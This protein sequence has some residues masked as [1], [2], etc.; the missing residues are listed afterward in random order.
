MLVASTP[1]SRRP[2]GSRPRTSRC[3]SVAHGERR[4]LIEVPNIDLA[5]YSAATGWARTALLPSS[6][7]SVLHPG[8]IVDGVKILV[9]EIRGH[10]HDRVSGREFWSQLQHGSQYPSSASPDQQVIIPNEGKTNSHR[11][12]FAHNYNP[13]RVGEVR[14]LWPHACANAGDVPLPEP[15]SECDRAHWLDCYNR[16]P[17]E[18]I[19]KS[20]RYAGERTSGAGPQNG[21]TLLAFSLD[22]LIRVLHP[23]RSGQSSAMPSHYAQSVFSSALAKR[24]AFTQFNLTSALVKIMTAT[25]VLGLSITSVEHPGSLPSW[26]Q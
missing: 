16:D 3:P 7:N 24:R 18:L 11:S 22:P 6:P 2:R 23:R 14:Q 19:T 17:W 20:L 26:P 13:I 12:C 1:R 15:A 4:R 8:R 21:S 9:A 25:L 5:P 10:G